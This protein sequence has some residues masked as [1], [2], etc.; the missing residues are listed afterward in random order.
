MINIIIPYQFQNRNHRSKF[1]AIDN[2]M[3]IKSFNCFVFVKDTIFIKHAN[4]NL[5]PKIYPLHG[6]EPTLHSLAGI[7]IIMRFWLL[8]WDSTQV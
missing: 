3:F 4:P 1:I 7:Q 2:L 6:I 5:Y 8:G